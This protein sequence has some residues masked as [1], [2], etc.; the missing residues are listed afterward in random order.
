MTN[1]C[2]IIIIIYYSDA[3]GDWWRFETAMYSPFL[4]RNLY[5]QCCE[6]EIEEVQLVQLKR[7]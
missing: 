4:G 7:L 3:G 5:H 6:N 2:Y 1:Y